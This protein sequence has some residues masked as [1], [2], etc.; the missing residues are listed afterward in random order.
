MK[1]M[2]LLWFEWIYL[3]LSLNLNN[4]EIYLILSALHEPT[5]FQTDSVFIIRWWWSLE[6]LHSCSEFLI[7]LPCSLQLSF[8]FGILIPSLFQ[9]DLRIFETDL[10]SR[11]LDDLS[12]MC[13]NSI[14]R[15]L[16]LLIWAL[17]G[18]WTSWFGIIRF[19]SS[20]GFFLLSLLR[21]LLSLFGSCNPSLF[22]LLFQLVSLEFCS[23][24]ILCFL[25]ILLQAIKFV[26]DAFIQLSV[27]CMILD[28]EFI[29]WKL[30]P[31]VI[32]WS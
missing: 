14:K 27:S 3:S 26:S 29:F 22:L 10:S 11:W 28:T 32:D 23:F 2:N 9:I 25:S 21:I 18:I 16:G 8:G 7:S 15:Q 13:S 19:W 6:G 20:L 5:I 4:F 17:V 12:L 24:G 31:S 1:Q 30:S